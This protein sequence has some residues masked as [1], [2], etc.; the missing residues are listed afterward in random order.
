MPLTLA[1]VGLGI[2]ATVAAGGALGV[3][4]WNV[5]RLAD[6][7]YV[8]MVGRRRV[9]LIE[10]PI[11]DHCGTLLELKARHVQHARVIPDARHDLGVLVSCPRCRRE[12]ALLTGVDAQAAL[13]QGL[14]YLNVRR[15]NRRKA[16]DAARVV[17]DAGGPDRLIQ[18]VARRELTLRSLRPERQL[19]LEMA[20]DE[21]AE[22]QELERQWRDAE[23]QAE[24]ADGTLSAN[25]ELEE[26]LQRLKRRRGSTVWLTKPIPA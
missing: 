13:R 19:A 5:G 25:A 3:V 20:V 4:V 2:A 18:D 22:A 10:P 6:S 23:E 12:A 26:E 7:V 17:N 16:D 21:Q 11:C 9:N 24:I 15:S 14:T 8:G 1:A